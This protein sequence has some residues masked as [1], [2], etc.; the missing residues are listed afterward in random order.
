[1]V[2]GQRMVKV[3]FVTSQVTLPMGIL[4]CGG[5]ALLYHLLSHYEVLPKLHSLQFPQRSHSGSNH[6]LSGSW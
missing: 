3:T 2:W 4:D 1:M 5:R 6:G